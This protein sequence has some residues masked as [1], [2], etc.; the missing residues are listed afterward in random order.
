VRINV[1]N[2]IHN[3]ELRI[4]VE[5]DGTENRG[6]GCALQRVPR[7]GYETVLKVNSWL[8]ELC[9]AIRPRARSAN[10]V[11]RKDRKKENILT[12]K[13]GMDLCVSGIIGFE[14]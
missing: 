4:R 7:C 13:A 10:L 1:W 11:G 3:E 12:R 6:S 2:M 8:R 9:C 14:G 5:Q